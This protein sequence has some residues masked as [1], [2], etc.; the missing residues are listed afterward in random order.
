MAMYMA[1]LLRFDGRIIPQY[2]DI[3][4]NTFMIL[5]VIKI[6]V[7]LLMG[8]YNSLWKYASIDELLQVFFATA[9]ETAL[10]YLYG[11]FKVAS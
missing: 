8:L 9:I 11:D 4:Y 2:R 5:T 3:F 1:L 6:S 10:Y 7:Y